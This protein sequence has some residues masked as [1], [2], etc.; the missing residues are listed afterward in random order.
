VIET[1]PFRSK[2]FFVDSFS[3][4]KHFDIIWLA[5]FFELVL[6]VS[7]FVF[8]LLEKYFFENL[9]RQPSSSSEWFSEIHNCK[10]FIFYFSIL[11]ISIVEPF[12]P[13]IQVTVSLDKWAYCYLQTWPELLARN[14]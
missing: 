3:K 9:Y 12:L 10:W 4:K 13:V 11:I 8:L 1:L 14:T 6:F 7:L 5:F 2:T